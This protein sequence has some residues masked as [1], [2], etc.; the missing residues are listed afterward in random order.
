MLRALFPL[1]ASILSVKGFI[2]S[3]TLSS[4]LRPPLSLM[5]MTASSSPSSDFSKLLISGFLNKAANFAQPFV[6]TKLFESD[7]TRYASITAATD[8][9][10]FAKKRMVTPA[11]VYNGLFDVLE[12]V[13]VSNVNDFETALEGKDAWLAFNVSSSEV[14]AFASLAAKRKL[15]RVVFGVHVPDMRGADVL[16]EDA[17]RV[18]TDAGVAFTIVKFA[19][20]K[21]MGE[22][23]SLIACDWPHFLH[24][25]TGYSLLGKISLSHSARRASAARGERLHELPRLRGPHA[26][27]GGVR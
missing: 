13:S 25:T 1:L 20:V 6:F 11:N 24:L 7:E 27:V 15:K 12:Y 26:R 9:L 23:Y 5:T 22:V 18:L 8:D 3:N 21:K 10:S 2:R 14:N 17:Q 4:S 16:F 19:D